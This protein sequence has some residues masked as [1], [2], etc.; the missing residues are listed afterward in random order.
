MLIKP[1]GMQPGA[2][3]IDFCFYK[4]CCGGQFYH[5]R[6]KIC[7][8]SFHCSLLSPFRL[9]PITKYN[10]VRYSSSDLS[11][12]MTVFQEPMFA[13]KIRTPPVLVSDA[14][15]YPSTSW[16]LIV[17][18]EQKSTTRNCMILEEQERDTMLVFRE[19]ETM[20]FESALN[21]YK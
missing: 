20:L 6:S 9:C 12:F 17:W 10:V 1:N 11:H 14:L 5:Q 2:N 13:S 7:C 21:Y 18:H 3:D 19:N 8:P 15:S 16:R 4:Q